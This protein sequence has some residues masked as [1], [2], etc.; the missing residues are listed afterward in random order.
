MTGL[1]KDSGGFKMTWQV[2]GVKRNLA[3]FVKMVNEGNDIV[4]SKKGSYIKTPTPGKLIKLNLENGTP[5][6][7]CACRRVT[8]RMIRSRL[9][10][11]VH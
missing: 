11:L 1:T 10:D 4:I 5:Q 7:E 6:F 3:S 9:G 2:T 8:R